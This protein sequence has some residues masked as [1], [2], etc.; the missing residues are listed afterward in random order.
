M[1]ISVGDILKLG[2][3]SR[4]LVFQGPNIMPE[5]TIVQI[6]IV[7]K[8]KPLATQADSHKPS[9]AYASQPQRT[10]KNWCEEHGVTY[11]YKYVQDIH[12]ATYDEISQ[13]DITCIVEVTYETENG[14]IRGKAKH[15]KKKEAEKLAALNACEII[16][17]QG[18]FA[19]Y[20]EIRDKGML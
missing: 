13:P 6:S 19:D 1:S 7:P 8:E 15:F 4:T 18:L 9:P 16:D 14:M 17:K 20:Y 12:D 5:D 2:E 11:S 10:L 3:S